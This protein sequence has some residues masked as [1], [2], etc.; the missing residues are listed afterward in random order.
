[1][2]NFFRPSRSLFIKPQIQV[3]SREGMVDYLPNSSLGVLTTITSRI[4]E[5]L[6]KWVGK[7]IFR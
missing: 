7:I 6:R 1:M 4:K 2:S 5:Y 3:A